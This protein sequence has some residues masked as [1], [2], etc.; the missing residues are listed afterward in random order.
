MAVSRV[1]ASQTLHVITGCRHNIADSYCSLGLAATLS[2]MISVSPGF[3]YLKRTPAPLYIQF[4]AA[5]ITTL[6]DKLD[7]FKTSTDFQ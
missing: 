3:P 7:R 5:H 6:A 4:I 1:L 2:I